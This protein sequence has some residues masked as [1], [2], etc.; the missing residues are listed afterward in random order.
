MTFTMEIISDNKSDPEAYLVGWPYIWY[1]ILMAVL[2]I[3]HYIAQLL[4]NKI[5]VRFHLT[6]YRLHTCNSYCCMTLG[7]TRYKLFQV[8]AMKE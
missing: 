2:K 3:P 4:T 6:L 5:N 8:H 7:T 1:Y